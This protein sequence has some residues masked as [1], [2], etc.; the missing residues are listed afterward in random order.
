MLRRL[1][2]VVLA[3]TVAA[4]G[5]SEPADGKV[6][7]R[8]LASPDVGGFSKVIIERFEK[9]NPG[10]KVEMIEGPS[11][12][13]ARENMYSTAFMA[14][15]DAYDLAY[16]DVAWLPKFA[17]QGWLRPLDDLLPPATAALFLPGDMEGSRYQGK[18]YRLPIQ[19]DGGMLYY[20]KDLLAAKGIPVPSTWAQLVAAAKATQSK[21]VAGF[22]FQGKQYEGLVCAFLEVVWGFGGDLL[23]A[24]G[25]VLV[26]RPEAVAALTALVDA[27]YKDKVVPQ[28]VLTYQEE[29]ARNAFQEGRAV[30]MRNW[31]YAWNLMQKEGSPV[32]G[33]VGIVPMVS[34]PGGRPAATLGGWGFALSAYSRHPREAYKLAEFF[35]S[36]ESQ[37]LAFLQGGILPTRRSLYSHPEVLRAA[38]H[39]KDLGRVLAAARPRPVHPRWPRMSDALQ[40]HVS[41][42]LSRQETPEEAL[43][44]AATEIRAA[45]AR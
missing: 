43:K 41:A 4:C 15:D 44:A 36:E 19:S 6:R 2:P 45:A 13:D 24:D 38:P 20:R 23:S 10:I 29:E 27:I 33:K 16:V 30:F 35:A 31:P 5:R 26:D 28:A 12:G 3:A 21:E 17:A 22:V 11:S 1:A 39:M 34:A 7:V 18:T 8:Y 40:M 42:A 37:K 32:R 25:E 14:E 9:A